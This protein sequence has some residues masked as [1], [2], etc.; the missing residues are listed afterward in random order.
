MM[1]TGLAA[2]SY[3]LA[4]HRPCIALAARVGIPYAV[5]TVHGSP[6][7][8]TRADRGHPCRQRAQFFTEGH[9]GKSDR[10]DL[11]ERCFPWTVDSI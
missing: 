5:G 1:K 6:S 7:S 9:L 11:R 10:S 4:A 3:A 8:D 2:F